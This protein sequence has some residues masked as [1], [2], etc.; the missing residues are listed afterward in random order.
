MSKEQSVAGKIMS[1]LYNDVDIF[2]DFKPMPKDLQGWGSQHPVFEFAMSTWRPRIYVE[3]GCWKGASAI[4]AAKLMKKHDIDGV[5]LTIDTWLGGEEHFGRGDL[6]RNAGYPQLYY[7][8]LA[9]CVHE[10]CHDRIVPIPTTSHIGSVVLKR[11]EIYADIVY[12]DASHEY[13]DVVADLESYSLLLS[14]SGIIIGDDYHWTWPGVV[15]AVQEFSQK[16]DL[17]LYI[18]NSKFILC[19]K[20]H[21]IEGDFVKVPR[22]KN[23]YWD[24]ESRDYV[25]R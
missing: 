8:F 17:D 13:Q 18:W 19:R 24:S 25:W 5:V 7:Q 20:G 14:P 15:R 3:V 1:K 11:N 4:H 22:P 9:N 6:H 16:H 2:A 12:L 23:F 21:V 10:N